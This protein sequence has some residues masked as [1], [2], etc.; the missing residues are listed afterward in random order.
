MASWRIASYIKKQRYR[1][2]VWNSCFF[3]SWHG[4]LIHTDVKEARN[5]QSGTTRDIAASLIK[6][7]L[8]TF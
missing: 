4:L 1:D 3:D 7:R 8:T 2:G 5:K 6:M